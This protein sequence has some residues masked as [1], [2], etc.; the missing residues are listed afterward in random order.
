[1]GLGVSLGHGHEHGL[2]PGGGAEEKSVPARDRNEAVLAE[3]V[4][5]DV[6][7]EFFTGD[8]CK[9]GIEDSFLRGRGR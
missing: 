5:R 9:K 7:G 8:I 1:M 4:G 3:L 2:P 6:H